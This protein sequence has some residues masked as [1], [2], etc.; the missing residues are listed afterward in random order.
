MIRSRGAQDIDEGAPIIYYNNNNNNT[1]R[2]RKRE[3]KSTQGE[4]KKRAEMMGGGEWI[5][6]H[7]HMQSL[8]RMPANFW[9]ENLHC[10]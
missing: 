9:C 10:H 8:P 7:I 4:K 1:K 6:E 5:K 3:Q 2:N